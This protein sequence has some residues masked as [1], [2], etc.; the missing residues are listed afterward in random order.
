MQLHFRYEPDYSSITAATQLYPHPDES[1]R[2]S[3]SEIYRQSF[4]PLH[5]EATPLSSKVA[6]IAV[7]LL[8]MY[9]K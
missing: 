3:L 7:C 4:A 5:A 2:F 6:R 1:H 9:S 8:G